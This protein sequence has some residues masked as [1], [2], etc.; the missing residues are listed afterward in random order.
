MITENTRQLPAK[1]NVL[2]GYAADEGMI[3]NNPVL[4][5]NKPKLV[6]KAPEIFSVDELTHY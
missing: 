5:V 1:Y 6:D 4:R 2:F 3:D